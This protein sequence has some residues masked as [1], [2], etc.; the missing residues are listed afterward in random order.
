M[1]VSLIVAMDE[2]GL[3][4]RDG[5]LPWRL[6]SDLAHFKRTTMGKPIVMGRRTWESIGRPLPGRRN[7]VL[8][9]TPGF[10]PEGA[11]VVP[12][13]EAAVRAAGDADELV[14]IGG[15]E[16]YGAFLA[17]TDRIY[18]TRVH[19]RFEGDTWFPPLDDREWV[20]TDVR[21]HAADARN[22]HPFTILRLERRRG[23]EAS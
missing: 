21:E 16:V 17:A 14:V 1:I 6:P 15:A 22:P 19:G 7:V 13:C 23:A 18:L 4:G 3:I 12:D 8:S 2:A 11:V 5:G 10:A 20:E 9:R